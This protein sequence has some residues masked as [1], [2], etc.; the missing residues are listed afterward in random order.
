MEKGKKRVI[1]YVDGFNF[2]YGLKDKSKEDSTWKKYYW[3]DLVKFF[4]S[5]I[6]DNQT[7]LFVKYFSAYPHQKDKSD[8]QKVLFQANRLNTKFQLI[9]GKYL[10][11]ERVCFN[12]GNKYRS[13]EEKETDVRLATTIFDDV[14]NNRCDTSIIVTADSDIV[15]TIDL[16]K[17][18]NKNHKIFTYF[19][20]KR[21]SNN[22]EKKSDAV[23][24]LNTYGNRFRD[25]ML[26]DIVTLKEGTT[27]SRPTEWK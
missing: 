13:Y 21:I 24:N 25:N 14:V 26:P 23:I 4:E 3:L 16:C 8:R 11:K 10:K 6:N 27:I 1:V 7:L 5:F 17:K 12:C 15:P 19:P 20:P 18:F 22:L 2:Y 9:L